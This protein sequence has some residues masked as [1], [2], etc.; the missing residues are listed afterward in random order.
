M[1]Y[2]T[3]NPK[4]HDVEKVSKLIYDVDFRTYDSLFL[5]ESAALKAISQYLS[6]LKP[7]DTFKVILKDSEIIG[8]LDTYTYYTHSKFHLK[9]LRLFLVEFLDLMV[10]CKIRKGDLY[11]AQLA[12]DSKLRGQGLGS[13]VLGDVLDYASKN[14][15]KRVTLDADF[16][17][18][19][20]KKLYEKMGFKVFNKKS[21][22]K[23]GMYNME[24]KL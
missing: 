2:E 21:F 19:K 14:S 8:V 3:F 15:F 4:I 16:R 22:L 12:I 5:N 9:S 6:K 11:I 13:E 7:R 24:F 20:A 17:N 1:I 23:R 18:P 10:I